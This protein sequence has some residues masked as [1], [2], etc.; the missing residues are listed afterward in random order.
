MTHLVGWAPLVVIAV[1]R[2]SS[3]SLF[4]LSFFT[5]L[6]IARLLKLSDSPPCN[7]DYLYFQN[8]WILS[9]QNNLILETCSTKNNLNSYWYRNCEE[10]YTKIREMR[11]TANLLQLQPIVLIQQ[12]VSLY[13]VHLKVNF[14]TVVFQNPNTYL[15]RFYSLTFTNFFYACLDLEKRRTFEMKYIDF[16]ILDMI[17]KCE[18]PFSN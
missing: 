14:R 9:V 6:S 3:S 17:I 4:S 5:R 1:I 15:C 10:N 8:L 16:F 7:F 2:L 13:K 18:V 12:T 11:W